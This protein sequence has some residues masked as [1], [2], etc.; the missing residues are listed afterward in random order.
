M[1]KIQI[2]LALFNFKERH[3]VPTLTPE[4]IMMIYDVGKKPGLR[5]V[6]VGIDGNY[7]YKKLSTGTRVETGDKYRACP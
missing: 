6:S 7:I 3:I 4:T 5:S 2:Y 1:S